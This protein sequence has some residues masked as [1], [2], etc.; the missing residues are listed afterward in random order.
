MK[1]K[2]SIIPLIIF[3]FILLFT[4]EGYIPF[5]AGSFLIIVYIIVWSFIKSNNK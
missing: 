3:I 5:E 4:S 2:K 1:K